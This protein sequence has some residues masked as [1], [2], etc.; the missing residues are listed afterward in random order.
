MASFR[1]KTFIYS[2]YIMAAL[3]GCRCEDE[4]PIPKKPTNVEFNCYDYWPLGQNKKWV[5]KVSKLI[6][7]NLSYV[8][9]DT[10]QFLKD[11]NLSL[12]GVFLFKEYGFLK[13]PKEYNFVIGNYPSNKNSL[14]INLWKINYPLFDL[15][16][17]QDSGSYQKFS[18]E[19]KPFDDR[20][21]VEYTT[22]KMQNF[23]T[24]LGKVPII[25]STVQYREPAPNSGYISWYMKIY[26]SKH[27]GLVHF[28]FEYD[29]K[30]VPLNKDSSL[31]LQYEIKEIIN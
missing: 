1:N 29:R 31:Y 14:F 28:T 2:L 18:A 8:Y 4:Q 19:G 15:M 12:T 23:N 11:T 16:E 25:N 7:S 21:L 24:S 17:V 13:M 9:D 26:T 3:S 27:M 20:Y 5:Y 30:N 22:P 6:N 10:L